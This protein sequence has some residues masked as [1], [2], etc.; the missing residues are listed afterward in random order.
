MRSTR[1]LLA[2]FAVAALMCLSGLDGQAGRAEIATSAPQRAGSSG[3]AV[4][5]RLHDG[6]KE[7]GEGL[8]GGIK[9]VGRTIISPFTGTTDK[10]GRDADATGQ[11]LHR[12]AKGFGEGLRDGLKYT[13]QKIGRFVS[14]ASSKGDR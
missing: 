6:A 14:D 10:V 11:R 7:F 4:G 1:S 2:A 3:D 8:L 13:G 12:G 5:T 9:F